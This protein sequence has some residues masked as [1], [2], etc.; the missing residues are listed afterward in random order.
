M[1]L[2]VINLE[3]DHDRRAKMR[4]RFAAVGL[5]PE[6]FP[7]VD[8][9]TLTAEQ[10]DVVDNEIRILRTPY[11]MGAGAIG[12]LLSHLSVWR[13]CAGGS[14]DMLAVFE[15]DAALSPRLPE[16]L[17][18][19]EQLGPRFDFVKLHHFRQPLRVAPC[20]DIGGFTLGRPRFHDFGT[21]GYVVSRAGARRALALKK[22]PL[23]V[24]IELSRWWD[25]GIDYFSID[26]PVVRHDDDG[27]SC[28]E[29][30]QIGPV[31]LPG[32]RGPVWYA[33]RRALRSRDSLA[34]RAKFAVWVADGRRR[35]TDSRD[36]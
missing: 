33:R 21:Q 14:D 32:A 17:A 7:A 12:C 27:Y 36:R 30:R 20:A 10:R 25:H 22:W 13:L 6:I 34:K 2:L 18:T 1:R 11:E 15:D 31:R 9:L 19:V 8:G 3:R 26:P 23:E 29:A 4:E 5:A 16:A 35:L 24:D 28:I